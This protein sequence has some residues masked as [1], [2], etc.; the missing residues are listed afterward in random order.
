MG[1][2]SRSEVCSSHYSWPTRSLASPASSLIGAFTRALALFDRDKGTYSML[3]I[4][5]YNSSNHNSSIT[6]DIENNDSLDL[7]GSRNGSPK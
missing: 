6:F 3:F 5:R 7:N 2:D 1:R 4:V